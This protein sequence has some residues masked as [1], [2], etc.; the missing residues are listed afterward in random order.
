MPTQEQVER[1]KRIKEAREAAGLSQEALG[2][3]VGAD[4][5]T[6]SKWENG[7]QNPNRAKRR[8]IS[9]AVGRSE[10]WIEHGVDTGAE[11]MGIEGHRRAQ[12]DAQLAIVLPQL[13]ALVDQAAKLLRLRLD[14]APTRRPVATR[15]RASV[16]PSPRAKGA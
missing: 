12:A 13:A 5:K 16:K 14:K 10:S 1:G 15:Q 11:E 8:G 3:A 7:H 6:V 2:R 4:E 9:K